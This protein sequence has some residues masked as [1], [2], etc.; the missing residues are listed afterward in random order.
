MSEIALAL[1]IDGALW[2]FREIFR[3]GRQTIA[4]F[5]TII[6]SIPFLNEPFEGQKLRNLCPEFTAEQAVEWLTTLA[7]EDIQKL[8]QKGKFNP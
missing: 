8:E 7:K 2:P 5:N 4:L 3:A 6:P 1:G